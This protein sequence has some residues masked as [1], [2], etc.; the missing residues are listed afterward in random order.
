MHHV[1]STIA[2]MVSVMHSIGYTH[3]SEWESYGT[4][5]QKG[6]D[7]LTELASFILRGRKLKGWKDSSSSSSWQW[8]GLLGKQ[9]GSGSISKFKVFL[10]G[11]RQTQHT[12]TYTHQVEM[13]CENDGSIRIIN[14]KVC[15]QPYGHGGVMT[16]A[17]VLCPKSWAGRLDKSTVCS[18]HDSHHHEMS[19]C[20]AKHHGCRFQ[21][22]PDR[23]LWQY[24]GEE[25]DH[26]RSGRQQKLA[27]SIKSRA[28]HDIK[29]EF[30]PAAAAAI[31]TWT[32]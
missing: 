3:S 32:V 2:N 5:W 10:A 16:K 24:Y 28:N 23:P 22:N 4:T 31:H 20:L 25:R 6:K 17:F 30:V 7:P 13:R 29:Q 14:R 19:W 21:I 1:H 9:R 12:H 18:F 11:K 27:S 15:N 26:T 8:D